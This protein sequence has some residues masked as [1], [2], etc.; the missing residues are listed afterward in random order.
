M[1][2]LSV[3]LEELALQKAILV[4]VDLMVKT[5]NLAVLVVSL[6]AAAVVPKMILS[7]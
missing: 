2:D 7:D 6:A 3:V 5:V 1:V 4:R